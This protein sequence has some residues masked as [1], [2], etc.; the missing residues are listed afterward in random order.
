MIGRGAAIRYLDAE[1]N[2]PW[3]DETRE[4]VL[5]NGSLE[6]IAA[7]APVFWLAPAEGSNE[8]GKADRVTGETGN[9]GTLFA[10]IARENIVAG[11]KGSVIRR[12][13]AKVL[14]D[15]PA[16]ITYGCN[17]AYLPQT[18]HFARDSAP[19]AQID[20]SAPCVA[21]SDGVAGDTWVWAWVRT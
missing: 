10:G 11:E 18:G 8:S 6:T 17:L 13:R 14:V 3:N 9:R 4:A 19:Q 15:D 2:N 16:V 1:P 20:L 21:L 7:M 5:E 12:G